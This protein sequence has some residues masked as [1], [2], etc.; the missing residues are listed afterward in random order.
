MCLIVMIMLQKQAKNFQKHVFVFL[1][2]FVYC[3][4]EMHNNLIQYVSDVIYLN[5]A[6]VPVKENLLC[7]EPGVGRVITR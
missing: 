2:K 7:N 6:G 5:L 4:N 1:D 3:H